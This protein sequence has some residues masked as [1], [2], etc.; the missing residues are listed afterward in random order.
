M[1][2]G[3]TVY[4]LGGEFREYVFQRVL[5]FIRDFEREFFRIVAKGECISLNYL[6]SD[7]KTGRICGYTLEKDLHLIAVLV[8]EGD[9]ATVRSG[10]LG[11][12]SEIHL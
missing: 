7:C 12:E 3:A 9:C 8:G 5:T 1:Q 6:R 4:R 11:I 2:F 10:R